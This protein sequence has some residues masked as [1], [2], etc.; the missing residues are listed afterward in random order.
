MRVKIQIQLAV[1]AATACFWGFLVG[2]GSENAIN[3]E[4]KNVA[5][6]LDDGPIP[7]NTADFLAVFSN[8][9]IRVNF[10]LVASNVQAFKSSAMVII[11]AGHEVVNH[12]C[13]HRKPS[14]C[15]DAQLEYEIVYGQQLIAETTGVTPKW[16][17]PPFLETDPRMPALYEKAGIK[18]FPFDK[19]VNTEDYD[20][21]VSAWGIRKR[22]TRNV[23]DGSVIVFHEWRKETLEQMPAILKELKQQNC[24]FLTF[25][26]LGLVRASTN[27]PYPSKIM[28]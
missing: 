9:N 26:E 8:A 13:T 27:Y 21:R 19:L 18:C 28:E 1:L 11:A 7:E 25:S 20:T 5:I 6:I 2:C 4:P 12:S 14:E 10:A 17:W 23:Q 24:V 3:T 22:A 16:Y 15:T